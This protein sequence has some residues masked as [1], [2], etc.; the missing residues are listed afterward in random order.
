[1]WFTHQWE[2]E[3]VQMSPPHTGWQHGPRKLSPL[4]DPP[5]TNQLQ[6]LHLGGSSGLPWGPGQWVLRMGLR[7]PPP[8]LLCLTSPDHHHMEPI[9]AQTEAHSS[10]ANVHTSYSKTFKQ[11]TVQSYSHWHLVVAGVQE[12]APCSARYVLSDPQKL[13]KRKYT[14]TNTT[15]SYL[16]TNSH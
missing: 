9:G 10:S 15:H 13:L 7:H 4:D 6:S 16:H 1:M 8:L 5:P 2:H 3:P 14:L 12:A 11:K